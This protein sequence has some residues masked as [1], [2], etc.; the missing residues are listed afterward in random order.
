VRYHVIAMAIVEADFQGED[1]C[2]HRP[3]IDPLSPPVLGAYTPNCLVSA[4]APARPPSPPL[5]DSVIQLARMLRCFTA[6]YA[7][8]PVGVAPM[9]FCFRITHCWDHPLQIPKPSGAHGTD[10]SPSGSSLPLSTL[11]FKSSL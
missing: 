6:W 7:M 11:L 5:V 1:S 2:P 10:R 8:H 3:A 4:F 9:P